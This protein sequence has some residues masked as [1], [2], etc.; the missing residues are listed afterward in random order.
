MSRFIA[1]AAQIAPFSCDAFY[2]D[3]FGDAINYSSKYHTSC[4]TA[5]AVAAFGAFSWL[6]WTATLVLVG[7][8]FHSSVRGNSRSNAI[9]APNATH[10]MSETGVAK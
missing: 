8:A 7:M 9:A 1:V 4:Q 3:A 5:K 10:E 6:L 2:Y